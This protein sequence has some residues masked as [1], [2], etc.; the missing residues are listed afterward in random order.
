MKTKEEYIENLATEL[1]AWSAQIDI[2][3]AKSEKA[4]ADVKI[5]YLEALED[6]RDKQ[7]AAA[8]KIKELEEANDDAL[9]TVK[10]TADKIWDDLRAGI[11]SA[12]SKFK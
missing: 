5:K 2:L 3:T 12:S 11:A 7:H 10:H 8:A 6:L 1:K 9:A 4:A